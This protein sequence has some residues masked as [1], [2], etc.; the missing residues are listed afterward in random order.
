MTFWERTRFITAV[1]AQA[2]AAFF[3]SVS[4]CFLVQ[5]YTDIENPLDSEAMEGVWLALLYALGFTFA[6]ALV[7]MS[8]KKAIP[9]WHFRILAWPAFVLGFGLSL[10]L[11]GIIFD[12]TTRT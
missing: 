8:L 7:S 10:Y 3:I 1:V 5:Y 4:V 12:L 9:K 6:S 2:I 11:G